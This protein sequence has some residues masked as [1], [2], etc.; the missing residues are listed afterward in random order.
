MQE[1]KMI[2]KIDNDGR[3]D[4]KLYTLQD[5]DVWGSGRVCLSI[6]KDGKDI[7][8]HF[9]KQQAELF[10]RRIAVLKNTL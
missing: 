7:T 1:Q 9:T 10:A 4:V 6:Y 3:V 8:I 5:A 2:L